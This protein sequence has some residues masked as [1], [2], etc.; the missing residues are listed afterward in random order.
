MHPSLKDRVKSIEPKTPPPKASKPAAAAVTEEKEKPRPKPNDVECYYDASKKTYWTRNAHDEWHELTQ[1][2]LKLLLR[3]HGYAT[4]AFAKND[5]N[6]AE[7]KILKITQ[8]NGVHFAGPLAGYPSGIHE[9]A[10][11]RVL[12][13]RGPKLIEPVRGASPTLRDFFR[14]LLG[15]Q[16]PTFYGWL[17]S[18]RQSLMSGAPWR[19]GQALAIAGPAG[20]GKSL[21]QN[22]ITEM[23]GGR[24]G[25]PYRYMAGLTTFNADLL[26]AEHLMIED[27]PSSFDI[28]TRKFF[29]S[30]LK[31]MT[32]NRTQ[33]H[34]SKGRDAIT[35]TP[36]S[37][38][39]ITLNDEPD[40]LMVLPP[41][42]DDLA[43]KIILLKADVVTFPY[44]EGDDKGYRRY[45]STLI[46]ELP[47][48]LYNLDRWEIPPAIRDKRFGVKAFHNEELL[49]K[50]DSQSPENHLWEMIE[51]AGIVSKNG[52]WWRGSARELRVSL[53]QVLGP[54]EVDS[55]LKFKTAA[56]TYL[57]RLSKKRPDEV[58]KLSSNHGNA[59]WQI[60]TKAEG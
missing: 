55:A 36:Y 21:C 1:S 6:L 27:D 31:I 4:D 41:I 9:V 32:V 50:L 59:V 22:L 14:Q 10:G 51:V 11:N 30:Q 43:D 12:V 54:A 28:R 18:A 33:S 52:G 37:R 13:T 2:N 15:K 17:K 20:C 29:G 47:A 46:D 56:G 57:E 48:F 60:K 3:S 49:G 5:L 53:V 25:K 38:I 44:K 19:P 8:E 45:W 23:L 34:H 35:L 58:Q 24:I 40:S 16:W 42:D 7:A 26:A 39:S